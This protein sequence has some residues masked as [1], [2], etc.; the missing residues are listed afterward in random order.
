MGGRITIIGGI[1]TAT[2]H[3]G[4]PEDVK[5]DVKKTID[6]L[7]GTRGFVLMDG[8]NVAPGT[9]IQNLNAVSEAVRE[10]GMY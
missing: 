3:D 2:L 1:D 5:D 4:T 10:V 6:I 8:H 9:P 7:K